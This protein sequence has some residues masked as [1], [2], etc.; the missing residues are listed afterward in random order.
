MRL[1]SC[2][3]CWF[4]GLQYGALGLAV[5]YCSRHKTILNAPD[6][7]TCGLHLRKDLTLERA[8]E[9]SEIHSQQYTSEFV[10]RILD[11][12]PYDNDVSRDRKDMDLLRKDAVAEVVADYGELGS[13]IESLAQL[14]VIPGARAELAMLSLGR[15]YVNN[16]VSKNGRWTSGLHLYWWS[17]KRLAEIPEIRVEDLR[18]VGAMQLSRQ[19][20]LTSW[21]LVML[22]LTFIED[23][24]IYA[25]QQG[26]PLGKVRSLTEQAALALDTFNLRILSKW[27]KSEAAPQLDAQLS[28]SR[29][30]ELAKDLHTE[31]LNA[32]ARQIAP[33]GS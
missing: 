8:K 13:T 3:N 11:G 6:G 10:A 23:I 17:R 15:G 33:A 1:H 18:S 28:S 29:Y 21:S 20:H 12:N 5:G 9:V 7:T 16:C 26:D 22:R 31:R 4:N 2:Q 24:T 27:L 30:A 14:K 25:S 32:E 19:T